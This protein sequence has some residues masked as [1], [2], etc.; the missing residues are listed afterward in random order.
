MPELSAGTADGDPSRGKRHYPTSPCCASTTAAGYI[1]KPSDIYRADA[2]WPTNRIA[3]VHV[4]HSLAQ[5][6]GERI[7]PG[8]AEL[9]ENM[10]HVDLHG[11]VG[12][13]K[14]SSDPLVAE[15][16]R[17]EPRDLLLPPAETVP[18]MRGALAELE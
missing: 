17:G 18:D 1:L 10:M 6:C 9:G 3:G 8:D 7:P 12:K 11:P 14:R 13:L 5:P 2:D 16:S 15:P 4:L